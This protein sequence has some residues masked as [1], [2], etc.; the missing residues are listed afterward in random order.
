MSNLD[1][2][3]QV[4]QQ[5]IEKFVSPRDDKI[6]FASILKQEL[7]T[8]HQLRYY[9]L[10]S[11]EEE[12]SNIS[13]F[14]KLD[15][16][17]PSKKNSGLKLRLAQN[18]E[19]QWALDQHPPSGIGLQHN[20]ILLQDGEYRKMASKKKES[21]SPEIVHSQIS[22]EEPTELRTSQKGRKRGR[23]VKY[24]VKDAGDDVAQMSIQ[25]LR[26]ELKKK[27]LSPGKGY[28]HDLVA[29]VRKSRAQ[30]IIPNEIE[31][32]EVSLPP[33][34]LFSDEVSI[35]TPNI[36]P[37]QIQTPENW[38][39]DLTFQR[40]V[41]PFPPYTNHNLPTSHLP[42][43]EPTMVENVFELPNYSGNQSTD[44]ILEPQ[45]INPQ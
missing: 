12:L 30:E 27:G 1:S 37:T 42:K 36:F 33:N 5:I 16:Y 3:H 34:G 43:I 44:S 31:T 28:K 13:K 4:F 35:P 8:Q 2:A 23:P 15:A 18:E 26:D 21:H 9:H 41:S 20:E 29:R 7:Q 32:K 45:S 25:E 6:D 10:M 24:C 39:S 40:L 11:L 14:Q 22:E 38:E 19:H 17:N